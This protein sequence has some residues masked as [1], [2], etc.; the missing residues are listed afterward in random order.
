MS[1]GRKHGLDMRTDFEWRADSKPEVSVQVVHIE[2]SRSPSSLL[3][4]AVDVRQRWTVL[5]IRQTAGT[6]NAVNLFLR[7]LRLLRMKSH[8]QDKG[9][10]KSISLKD[11]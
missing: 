8:H 2:N 9:H 10:D 3:D 1:E 7:F 5:E 11:N 6:Y 4:D